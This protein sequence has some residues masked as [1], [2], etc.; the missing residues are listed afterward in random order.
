M[1]VKSRVVVSIKDVFSP[2]HEEYRGRYLLAALPNHDGPKGSVSFSPKYL[3]HRTT[4][5]SKNDVE[6]FIKELQNRGFYQFD[7]Q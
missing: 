3:V 1:T 7:V 6:R 4:Y 5:Q 2:I